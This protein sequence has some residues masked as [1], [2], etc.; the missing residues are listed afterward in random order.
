MTAIDLSPILTP[1]VQLAGLALA[2]FASWAL[3]QVAAHYKISTQSAL[4]QNVL[5]AVDRGIAYGQTVVAAKASNVT[6]NTSN[7]VAAEAANYVISKMPDALA[8]LGM[9]P[10]HVADLVTAR[11][12][13][14]ISVPA[15]TA[16]TP[17]PAA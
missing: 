13:Q 1:L 15:A 5:G 12:P 7:A 10:A 17:A 2:G 4:F 14:P 9:T 16:A 8:K 3:S 6:I 11:L